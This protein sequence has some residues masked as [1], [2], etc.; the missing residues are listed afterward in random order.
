MIPIIAA[1]S[2][3]NVLSALIGS[4]D[5]S[6]NINITKKSDTV[7]GSSGA[8]D[9]SSLS[10][11]NSTTEDSATKSFLD[12]MKKSPAQRLRDAW[13]SAHHLTEDS[14]KSMSAGQREAIEK[15]IANDIKAQMQQQA[16]AKSTKLS[17]GT[18]GVATLLASS[19]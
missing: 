17:T 5:S 4:S 8:T 16:Q 10:A 1:A 18:A 19:L 6:S 9:G 11:S 2:A 7:T 12:Y 13:L 15:Q 14:L 3:L